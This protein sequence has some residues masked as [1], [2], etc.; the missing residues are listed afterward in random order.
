MWSLLS[1]PIKAFL[2]WIQKR[3][4][5]APLEER[6]RKLLTNRPPGV[7]WMSMKTLSRQIGADE[8]ETARLLIKIGAR[9]STGEN[10]VWALETE[11]PI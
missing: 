10:D 6:L 9:R 3:S 8:K 2:D 4:E 7:E 1:S 11:K 5:D